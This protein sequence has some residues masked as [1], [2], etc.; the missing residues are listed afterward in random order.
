MLAKR[1]DTTGKADQQKA[2]HKNQRSTEKKVIGRNTC[3]HKRTH[4]HSYIMHRNMHRPCTPLQ[5]QIYTHT[6]MPMGD[7]LVVPTITHILK[8]PE[9]TRGQ[10]TST[11]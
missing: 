11:I 9:R 8:T 4:A 1:D 7:S 6:T 5:V 2:G 10:K 3:T